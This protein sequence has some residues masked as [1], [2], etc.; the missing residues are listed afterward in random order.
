MAGKHFLTKRANDS[1]DTLWDRNFI[2]IA[3]SHTI[4]EIS[5]LLQFLAKDVT[6]N[7]CG[8]RNNCVF[9]FYSEIK[10]ACFE[11]FM[12]FIIIK[13]IVTFK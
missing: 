13:N 2:Q 5:A 7:C 12:I 8:L 10:E 9:A 4:S 11:I 6:D 1:A 3:L